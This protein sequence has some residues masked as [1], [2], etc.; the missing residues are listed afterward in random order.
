MRDKKRVV[1]GEDEQAIRSLVAEVLR[2]SGYE[3]E[4]AS[5][6]TEVLAALGCN[7]VAAL[8]LDLHL[9][10]ARGEDLWEEIRRRRP[11]LPV[12]AMTG[13]HDA[14]APSGIPCLYK[15]FS[16]NELRESV[17]SAAGCGC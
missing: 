14:K 2:S 1:V 13:D 12:I 17:S 6:P 8:V 10:T 11:D 15:P 9:G 7:S 3:V 4:E 5:A 16:V